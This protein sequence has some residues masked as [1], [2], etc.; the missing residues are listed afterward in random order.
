MGKNSPENS[1]EGTDK[2]GER[3]LREAEAAKEENRN[4]EKTTGNPG[5]ASEEPSERVIK[6]T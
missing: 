3:N 2:A 4:P 1:E 5:I 6:S